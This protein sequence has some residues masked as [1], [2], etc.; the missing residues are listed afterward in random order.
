MMK[1]SCSDVSRIVC[2]SSHGWPP[3]RSHAQM[4]C[5]MSGEALRT[6]TRCHIGQARP[7]RLAVDEQRDGHDDDRADG[8]EGDER[9]LQHL[10]LLHQ[11]VHHLR[12]TG[13]ASSSLHCET[14]GGLEEQGRAHGRGQGRALR[15]ACRM[16]ECHS[17][18][19]SSA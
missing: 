16:T 19:D 11:V 4:T 10:V 15:P 8:L 3:K 6:T 9:V 14:R 18:I 2:R 17:S 1:P 13:D 7:A 5:R 12:A